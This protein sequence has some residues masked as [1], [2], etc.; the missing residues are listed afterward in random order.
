MKKS[1]RLDDDGQLKEE[2]R[3][4]WYYKSGLE[5]KI[6]RLEDSKDANVTFIN[7]VRSPEKIKDEI[8]TAIKKGVTEI[9]KQ[10]ELQK[11]SKNPIVRYGLYATVA[12]ATVCII[13]NIIIK[14]NTRM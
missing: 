8:F 1:L 12:L 3:E 5:D 10:A 13:T 7:Q 9:P 4:C 2:L 6:I 11:K 14:P